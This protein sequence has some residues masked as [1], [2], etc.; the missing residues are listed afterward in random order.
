MIAFQNTTM[1]LTAEELYEEVKDTVIDTA[2]AFAR[3]FRQHEEDMVADAHM[4]FMK[5]HSAIL[6]GKNNSPNHRVEIKRWVWYELFDEYRTRT[7]N[8]HKVKVKVEGGEFID[9][10]P[11]THNREFLVDFFDALSEDAKQAAMLVLDP[12]A[13]VAQTAR[14]K[15]GTDCNLRSTVR[16]HLRAG[17]WG[18][19]RI[20]AAFSEVVA[21]LKS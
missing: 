4:A 7:R 19:E 12:P 20:N 6:R 5:G 15:G 21:A 1:Q 2:R 11:T 9:N 17:G 3:K 13:D 18:V 14:A 8:R 16:Q 10:I